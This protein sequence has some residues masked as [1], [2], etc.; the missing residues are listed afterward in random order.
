MLAGLPC[1]CACRSGLIGV[2][3]MAPTDDLLGSQ[4]S[5]RRRAL[6]LSHKLAT[7]SL[8]IL[9]THYCHR[10]PALNLPGTRRTRNQSPPPKWGRAT[11]IG[12]AMNL[13][14]V[15]CTSK[16]LL[17]QSGARA[18]QKILKIIVINCCYMAPLGD[19]DT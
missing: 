12:R 7:G 13:S 15:C 3:R 16:R 4:T 17:R 18:W 11:S 9:D 2:P 5:K 14:L 19:G 10:D 6:V 8:S 1:F